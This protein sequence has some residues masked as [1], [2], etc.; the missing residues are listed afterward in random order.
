MWS[1]GVFF[2]WRKKM[3]WIVLVISGV[4]ESVWAT[5]LGRIDGMSKPI[6]VIVFILGLTFSM[7]GLGYSMRTISAGTAYV[8]WTG[9]GAALTVIIGIISGTET[10]SLAKV[11]L[12]IGLVACVAGLKIVSKS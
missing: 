10:V 5:A 2:L 12:L 3:S 6:P 7:L 11:L 8:V 1:A 9:I 4:M